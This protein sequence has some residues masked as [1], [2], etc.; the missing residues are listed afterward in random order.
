MKKIIL[1][2]LSLICIFSLVSCG[3]KESLPNNQNTKWN[4]VKSASCSE[5]GLK[6]KYVNGELAQEAIPALGHDYGEWN[7][8]LKESC[9]TDG[10]EERQC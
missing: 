3:N 10:K 4:I 8:N 1:I 2:F 9:T 6:E 5:E 7:V